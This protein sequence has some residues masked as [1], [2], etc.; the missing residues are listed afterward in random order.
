MANRRKPTALKL[1]TGNPGHQKLNKTE[2][3]PT[4][5]APRMP[6]WLSKEAKEVW[7]ALAPKLERLSLLTE[8]DREAFA[9]LCESMGMYRRAMKGA[10]GKLTYTT[11]TGYERQRPELKIAD[12]AL[13]LSIR[14]AAEFGLT[15]A[16]RSKISL[17]PG[18]G[19][20][21]PFEEFFE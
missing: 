5:K 10:A 11:P 14:L 4:P 21:D 17:A 6:A 7:R 2:P 19:E 12:Q 1:I 9:G 3:K 20:K 18:N 16:S 8:I 13:A 15:P